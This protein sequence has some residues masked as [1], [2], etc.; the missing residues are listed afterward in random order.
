MQTMFSYA[1]RLRQV[2]TVIWRDLRG[3]S[4]FL[5]VCKY[6]KPQNNTEFSLLYIGPL[7]SEPIYSTLYQSIHQCTNNHHQ[8]FHPSTSAVNHVSINMNHPPIH[9][10]SL[11]DSFNL[12]LWIQPT[13]QYC[14]FAQQKTF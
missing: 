5:R 8:S 7:I 11:I 13:V 4:C 1:D 12:I 6:T 3:K 14:A 2:I 9:N 10:H